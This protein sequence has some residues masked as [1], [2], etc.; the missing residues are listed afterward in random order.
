MSIIDAD[1]LM[2]AMSFYQ[3]LGYKPIPA[4]MLVDKDIVELT[5]PKGNEAREHLGKYYVGSAEQSFYQLIKDGMKPDG[6]YMMITPCERD[7]VEDELHLGIFLKVEL[8]STV[9]TRY[10]ILKDASDFLS[11]N[12]IGNSWVETE[13][14]GFDLEV[15]GIEV[16]SYGANKYLGHNIK[17]GTGIALPR[18][19]KATGYTYDIKN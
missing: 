1:L 13:G 5:L 6:S 10:E 17:F 15:N 16:G 8:V 12:R 7:E 2:K 19:T 4:P 3:A 9:K 11:D 18:L 14:G